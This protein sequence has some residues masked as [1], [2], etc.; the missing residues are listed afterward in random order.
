[1]YSTLSWADYLYGRLTNFKVLIDDWPLH[2]RE[3][4]SVVFNPNVNISRD[5]R[6]ADFLYLLPSL[7]AFSFA[8]IAGLA[9]CPLVSGKWNRQRGIALYL[10][11]VGFAISLVFGVLMFAPGSTFNHHGSYAVQVM[12]T[13]A[14]FMVL[15]LCA[16]ALA[17]MFIALQTVTVSVVYGLT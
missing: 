5:I 13:M 17:V 1:S 4:L 3:L 7:H 8:V 14:A 2:L 9:L 16:P 15:S 6:H 11:A 12:A 10:F